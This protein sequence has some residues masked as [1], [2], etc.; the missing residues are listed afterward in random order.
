[1]WLRLLRC[2]KMFSDFRVYLEGAE[3]AFSFCACQRSWK[4]SAETTK[5]IYST[6]PSKLP[7]LANPKTKK[8]TKPFKVSLK[9]SEKNKYSIM[10][11]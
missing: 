3:V 9:G 6:C 11:D 2:L 7:A 8:N 5:S 1:M 10:F 4:D